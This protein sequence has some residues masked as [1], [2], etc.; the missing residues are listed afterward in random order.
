MVGF[1]SFTNFQSN[2]KSALKVFGF[3]IFLHCVFCTLP[4]FSRMKQIL[5]GF[6][7]GILMKLFT[8][9]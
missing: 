9:S 5:R 2:A 7:G 8:I 1:C 3:V 4:F 6:S